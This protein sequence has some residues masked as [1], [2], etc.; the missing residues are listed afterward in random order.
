M[1]EQRLVSHVT[2]TVLY[3]TATTFHCPSNNTDMLDMNDTVV[4]AI[5]IQE[6]G[7][8]QTSQKPSRMMG[9][10]MKLMD[11]LGIS[12]YLLPLQTPT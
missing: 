2:V 3:S 7:L 11:L 10:G 5:V 1:I 12:I 8:L 6:V 9:M 4:S